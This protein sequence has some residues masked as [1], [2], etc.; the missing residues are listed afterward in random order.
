MKRVIGKKM[1]NTET[2]TELGQYWNG[3]G[4]SDF[5]NLEETLYKTSKGAYFLHGSGG[6]MTK[7]AVS[8]GSNSTSGSSQIIP[9]SK[10]EAI[11][12]AEDNEVTDLFEPGAEFAD[13][14]EDA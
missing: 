10:R 9:L 4:T 13:D 3:L 12:W 14:I 7:Y 6:P 1:Y 2:A 11:Q 8:A 5:R